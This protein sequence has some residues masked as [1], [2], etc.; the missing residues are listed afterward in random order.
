MKKRERIKTAL[1]NGMLFRRLYQ[2]ERVKCLKLT[3]GTEPNSPESAIA[4]VRDRPAKWYRG[5]RFL[6]KPTLDLSIILPV[7]DVE[8]YLSQ[9]LEALLEWDGDISYEVV[10]VDDGSSDASP[11]ILEEYARRFPNLAIIK[12]E[13]GGLSSARNVGL[14]QSRGRF[15][16]FVDS[17]DIMS[18]RDLHTLLKAVEDRGLDFVSGEYERVDLYGN[19]LGGREPVSVLMVPWGR[20]FKREVWS[21]VRFPEGCWYEDVVTPFLVESRFRGGDVRGS[22]YKYRDRPGSIV[23]STPRDARGLDSFWLLGVMLDECRRLSIPLDGFIY[24]QTLRLMGPL[25]LGRSGAAN[26]YQRRCLF[27]SCCNLL[28]NT[29]EFAGMG[30]GCFSEYWSDLELALRTRNYRLWCLACCGIT[31]MEGGM[32]LKDAVSNYLTVRSEK[33]A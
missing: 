7:Y 3:G 13:N 4:A 20:V 10:A 14:E 33:E 15:V 24:R 6:H 12:K 21:D 8:A 11:L 1:R 5:A 18:I 27:F 16:A 31:L 32:Y 29:S 28:A 22:L 26:H 25:L 30:L 2:C 19:V 17:D 23:T 9:C